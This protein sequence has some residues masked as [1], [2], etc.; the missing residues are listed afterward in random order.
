VARLETELE[1][2]RPKPRE[3][4]PAVVVPRGPRCPGCSLPVEPGA[5]GTCPWCGFVFETA[6]ARRRR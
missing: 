5:K 4:K 2:L 6:K 1:A 3:V